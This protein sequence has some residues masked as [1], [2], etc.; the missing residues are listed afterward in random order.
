MIKVFGGTSYLLVR[1][2]FGVTSSLP[3]ATDFG[4]GLTLLSNG[5]PHNLQAT[6]FSSHFGPNS[7]LSHLTKT[8]FLLFFLKK[9]R[10]KIYNHA[11]RG[12][13]NHDREPSQA[14]R[15]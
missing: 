15:R 3:Q 1:V 5:R 9:K 12:D 4:H 11:L 6:D 7:F 2:I 10:E 8:S 14:P 13:G